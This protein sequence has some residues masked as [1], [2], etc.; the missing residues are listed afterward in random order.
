MERLANVYME[1][2]VPD[3]KW[4]TVSHFQRQWQ[5]VGQIE[6]KSRDISMDE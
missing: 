3:E 2:I 1:S 4:T 5:A 6:G